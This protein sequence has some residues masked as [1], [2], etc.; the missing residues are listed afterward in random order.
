MNLNGVSKIKEDI[1]YFFKG[2]EIRTFCI[3]SVI[4]FF[5]IALCLDTPEDIIK[6]MYKII[7][8]RDV[9]ITDYI[10]LA[11]YGAAFLNASIMMLFSMVL[12]AVS[13]LPY[14]GLTLAAVFISAGFGLW[15]KN[16]VNMLPIVAG[17]L[18]YAKV[19]KLKI[20]KY[21]F[22]AIF[23]GCLSPFVTEFAYILPF[24]T[25][26]NIICA[27]L[28]GVGMGFAIAPIATHTTTV[29]MGYSLFNVGFAGGALGFLVYS[30][31]KSLGVT[32]KTEFIW[33]EGVPP[34]LAVGLFLFFVFTFWFGFIL[35]GGTISGLFRIMK[36][37]GRTV[38]D[39]VML[40]GRGN[41]LMNMAVMGIF[42]EGFI[43]CIGGDLSGPV[44][45]CILTVF[46][47]SAF[48]AH[49]KNYLPVLA[50]VVLACV[51]MT[52]NISDPA[53]QIAALL[54]VGVAPIAGEFGIF[55]GIMAGIIHV[56][57]VNCTS[58]FYGGL[59]LYNNGFS[60]GWVALFMVPFLESFRTNFKRKRKVSK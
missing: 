29:H 1:R 6:G 21:T 38:T 41:T 44:L 27:L 43:I 18:L 45:G 11:G 5:L 52:N 57:I 7:I 28:L 47:F 58:A 49:L 22:T 15:G 51:F 9:L 40:E 56:A 17:T 59:N 25:P 32:T 48:G 34:A 16:P 2:V 36:H 3:C 46:G 42:C 37:P 12:I 19:H 20:T 55:Q 54:V 31:I 24:S 30:F 33:Q 23:A 39:F 60:T 13:R 14:T 10:A 50:G 26:V 8:S 35:E 4:M 53:M